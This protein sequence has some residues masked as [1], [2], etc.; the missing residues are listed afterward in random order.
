[1]GKC[2]LIPALSG[3]L[4]VKPFPTRNMLRMFISLGFLLAGAWL[5][6]P[7]SPAQSHNCYGSTCLGLNPQTL[8]MWQ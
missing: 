1:M 7:E 8:W 5:P 6:F 2:I 4:S 3:I